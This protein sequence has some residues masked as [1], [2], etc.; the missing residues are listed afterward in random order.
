[1]NSFKGTHLPIPICL[2]FRRA[3]VFF[4]HRAREWTVTGFRMISPSLISFRIC[5]PGKSQ[6]YLVSQEHRP[7][8]GPPLAFWKG[9][10]DSY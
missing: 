10:G 2:P 7:H 1:M 9:L 3:K 6:I 8:P 5:W 4:R